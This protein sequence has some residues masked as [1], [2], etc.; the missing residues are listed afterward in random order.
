MSPKYLGELHNCTHFKP[1]LDRNGD[2]CCTYCSHN[3]NQL[4]EEGNCSE[5]LCPLNLKGGI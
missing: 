3:G 4:E 2:I 1:M 5:M